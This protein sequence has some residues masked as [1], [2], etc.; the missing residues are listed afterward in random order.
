[1]KLSIASIAFSI[2]TVQQQSSAF[3]V[4]S[5][6]PLKMTT[7]TETK[8]KV[9]SQSFYFLD[10]IITSPINEATETKPVIK[11]AAIKPKSGGANHKKGLFS[12]LVMATKEVVGVANLNKIRAQAIGLHSKAIKSFVDTNE[13]ALGSNI[14]LQLFALV[15]KNHDGAVDEDELAVAFKTL[16]FS[17]LKEKQ[18]AGIIKRSGSEDG[19]L[20]MEQFR[21]EFPKT[22]RVNLVKLA[23]KNGGELGFLV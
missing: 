20:R 1:M 10:E 18:I 16:G 7:T 22:L 2:A 3:S 23:K 15:D 19:I 21:H 5:T 6:G 9:P 12:P 11:K 13:T 8:I 4:S 14:V 17:W